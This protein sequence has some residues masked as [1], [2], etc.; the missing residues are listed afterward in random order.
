MSSSSYRAAP[1]A[2]SPGRD[3]DPAQVEDHLVGRCG[4]GRTRPPPAGGAGRRRRPRPA[5]PPGPPRA[6]M[7]SAPGSPASRAA[8]AWLAASA[9]LT[10]RAASARNAASCS[11]ARIGG[12]QVVDGL[13]DEAR[14]RIQPS[15]RPASR[16]SRPWPEASCA[17]A[18]AAGSQPGDLGRN[19]GPETPA[20]DRRRP[21]VPLRRF[22]QACRCGTTAAGEFTT[23]RSAT[24]A[25]AGSAR[26]A[27]RRPR[28]PAAAGSRC[29]R[30]PPR[31]LIL[32]RRGCGTG[33]GCCR[34]D[35]AAA[36]QSGARCCT[37]WP[38]AG[39]LAPRRPV[40]PAAAR[41]GS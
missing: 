30:R 5:G 20:Q 15:R 33:L 8:T 29:T 2:R 25:P 41:A 37:A 36:A 38:V 35:R 6:R 40:A 28:S 26:S 32:R 34:N 7:S 22:I 16:L 19:L 4:S 39:R 23:Y 27:S 13:A 31:H 3:Q 24:A 9:G 18:A 17:A 12:G 11:W 1:A 10:P 14:G 21:Q